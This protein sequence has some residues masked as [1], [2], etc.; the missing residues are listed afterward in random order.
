MLVV[1]VVVAEPHRVETVD[2]MVVVVLEYVGAETADAVVVVVQTVDF[3]DEQELTELEIADACHSVVAA[4][5]P[6]TVVPQI[7]DG[8]L[9]V[10][11]AAAA[12]KVAV[13]LLRAVAEETAVVVVVEHPMALQMVVRPGCVPAEMQRRQSPSV[14]VQTL[15]RR[16]CLQTDPA[17]PSSRR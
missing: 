17:R 10:P 5:D 4:A 8:T 1:V 13:A 2:R 6:G 7:V 16:S 11:A 3:G 12:A 14:S 15:T 9:V